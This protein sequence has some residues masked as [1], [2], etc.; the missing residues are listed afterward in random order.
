VSGTAASYKVRAFVRSGDKGLM[1]GKWT[2]RGS[3][4]AFPEIVFIL[5]FGHLPPFPT[6]EPC[7]VV[8]Y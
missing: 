3:F 4:F 7:V 1:S 8:V 6:E 2:V 5:D